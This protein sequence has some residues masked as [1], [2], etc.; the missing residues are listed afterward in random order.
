VNSSA[1]KIFDKTNEAEKSIKYTCLGRCI[2]SYSFFTIHNLEN[3]FRNLPLEPVSNR[4][5]MFGV[6]RGQSNPVYKK[7][8][9]V[10][11]GGLLRKY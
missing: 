1:L 9:I 10:H 11:P 2:Y 8:A 6:L 5:E 4:N 3:L 7:K